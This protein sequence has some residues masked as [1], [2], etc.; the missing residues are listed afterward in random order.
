MYVVRPNNAPGTTSIPS[1]LA[2]YAVDT[3]A[4]LR[5]GV[6]YTDLLTVANQGCR[7]YSRHMYGK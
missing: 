6:G 7:S 1:I 4:T 3:V 2:V 5:T